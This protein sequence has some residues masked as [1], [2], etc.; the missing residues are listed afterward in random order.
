[1][2]GKSVQFVNL[3]VSEESRAYK[4][5][6]PIK[7]KVTINRDVV[8]EETKCWNQNKESQVNSEDSQVHVEDESETKMQEKLGA[9][10]QVVT[11]NLTK[12]LVYHHTNEENDGRV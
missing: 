4:L 7:G 9:T 1:M 3:S 2:D 8:F 6:E 12:E 5:F 10:T 11:K